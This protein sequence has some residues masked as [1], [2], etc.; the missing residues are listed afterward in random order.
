MLAIIAVPGSCRADHWLHVLHSGEGSASAL[1]C[2]LKS[3]TVQ[4]V[5]VG[6]L[7]LS[8]LTGS[9]IYWLNQ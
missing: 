6:R 1:G 5:S 4:N 9:R 7:C 8:P 2:A 3:T